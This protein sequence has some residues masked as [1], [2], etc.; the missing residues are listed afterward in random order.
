MGS[1]I[2]RLLVPRA[3]TPLRDAARADRV[4]VF[5]RARVVEAGTHDELLALGGIYAGLWAQQEQRSLPT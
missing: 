4:V 1:G 3:A 5:D 2:V